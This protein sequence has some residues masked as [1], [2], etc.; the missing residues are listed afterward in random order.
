MIKIR[1]L[2]KVVIG[3][4]KSLIINQNIISKLF[5]LRELIGNQKLTAFLSLD[6][7]DYSFF[8]ANQ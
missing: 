6:G 4:I 1:Y 5:M 3:N 8:L 2:A 7:L